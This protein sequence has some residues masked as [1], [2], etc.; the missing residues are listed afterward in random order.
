MIEVKLSKGMVAFVSERDFPRVS[1][2]SWYA[3][4][5]SRG[6]K[7]YAIRWSRKADPPH[8]T[9]KGRYKIR[10]HHFVLDLMPW[11][12]PPGHVV[13]H[14]DDDGLNCT[15]INLEIID[16]PTNMARSEGWKKKGMRV[17]PWL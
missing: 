14:K 6:T 13:H 9:K 3:S 8:P 11:D 16:Q 15:D 5:E 10:L 1:A 12:L 7:V 17:Q 4:V 2:H